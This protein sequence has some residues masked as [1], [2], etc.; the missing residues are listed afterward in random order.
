M[1]ICLVLAVG[2]RVPRYADGLHTGGAIR[3]H[4]LKEGCVLSQSYQQRQLTNFPHLAK[5]LEP[6][7]GG[8]VPV[9]ILVRGKDAD[10]HAKQ[11]EKCL[12][13]IKGGGVRCAGAAWY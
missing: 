10:Q 9:E 11:L 3:C 4:H 5:H 2:L 12:D 1:G 6:L 13:V 8:K 7:K